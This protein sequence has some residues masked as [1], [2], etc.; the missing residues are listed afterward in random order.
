MGEKREITDHGAPGVRIYTYDN[1]VYQIDRTW[2]GRHGHPVMATTM[3]PASIPDTA[4]AAV[5]VDRLDHKPETV[6]QFVF[7]RILLNSL[8]GDE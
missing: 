3:L 7:A 2:K 4:L 8:K 5:L 1:G 6:R